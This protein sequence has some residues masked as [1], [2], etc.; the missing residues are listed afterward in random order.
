M[1]SFLRKYKCLVITLVVIIILVAGI[2]TLY[3]AMFQ[4]NYVFYYK[5]NYDV[6][7]DYY[8]SKYIPVQ[9][10]TQKELYSRGR[11]NDL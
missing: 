6:T 8:F 5:G 9:C 10:I 3:S 11:I 7:E 2:S 1:K 4:A